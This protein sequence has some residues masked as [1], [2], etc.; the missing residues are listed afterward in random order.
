[1]VRSKSTARQFQEV[2][3]ITFG[4]DK[5]YPNKA[6]NIKIGLEDIEQ[7]DDMKLLGVLIDSDLNFSKHIAQVCRKASQQIGVLSRLKNLVPVPAKLTLFKSAISSGT[8][9]GLRIN[10]N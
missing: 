9:P 3:T 5:T 6:I 8:L 1:M 4:S 2:S 10:V 7:K